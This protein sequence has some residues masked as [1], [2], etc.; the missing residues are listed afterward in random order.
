MNSTSTRLAGIGVSP[1]I[2]S[3]PVEWLA[4]PPVVPHDLTPAG[5]PQAEARVAGE[6]VAATAD[7]LEARS[8]SVAGPAADVLA[9]QAMM[10]RDPVLGDRIAELAGEGLAAAVA[11]AM[12][13][14][15]FREQL[16]AA[17]GYM[18]ERA[19]DLADI[20]NRAVARL[21]GVP[22]PG[23]PDLDYSFVLLAGDLSPADTVNL[24]PA[25]VLAIVTEHGGPTSHTA[26][27]SKS[28][29]LPAVV[30]CA[31]VRALATGTRVMVDGAEGVV[32]VD[33]AAALVDERLGRLAA[34]RAALTGVSGPG[35]TSDG[36]PVQLLINLGRERD[37]GVVAAA[38]AEGVGLYRT[39]FLFLERHDAPTVEEQRVAYSEVFHAFA[40]RKVVVRTLD[41]GAD[42]PLRFVTQPDEP[43]PALGV[44]GLRTSRLFPDL[45]D[46]QLRAIARAAS[47]SG[48]DVWV[49]AP[50]VSTAGEAAAFAAQAHSHGV[51]VAGVMIEVP[52]AALQAPAVA[53]AC[54]FLSLGTNDLA[55]Y[56]FAADR[57]AGELA[58]LLDPWQ[59]ALLELIRLTADAGRAS[60][61][62]VGV[63]G[64]AASD[65]LLALVL[66]GFGVTSLSMATTSLPEVR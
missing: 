41:A 64:E 32:I 54:D 60:G 25:H 50:M 38:D 47:G 42:K 20:R 4:P 31:G 55:Q 62:P 30:G 28:L 45:L 53:A 44:R 21:L 34:R 36:T 65:P 7:D 63:C 35:R 56:T 26:I 49:M 22:M 11:V 1:G 5:D 14:D 33:P 27:I 3:G 29:G 37:L 40:G 6:A 19:A 52:A 57:M 13:F 2:A 59:P 66:V 61:R 48:A 9:A 18:A 23:V 46:G 8:S 15:E 58:D 43:N 16:A 12:A 39:E 10:A 17:G 51:P 24:D